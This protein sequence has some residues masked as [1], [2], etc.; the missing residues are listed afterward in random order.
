MERNA[1][2]IGGGIASLAA[3]VYLIRDANFPG[4]NIHIIEAIPLLGGSN[5]GAGDPLQGYVN[6]GGRMLNEETYEN[7]WDLLKSIPSLECPGMNLYEEIIDFDHRHPTHSNARLIDKYG[8]VCDVKKMGLNNTDRLALIKLALSSE[9]SLEGM[10]IAKWFTRSPHFFQ[11][12]FWY[13]WQTTFAFQKWSS[14]VELQ[15]YMFRFLHLFPRIETLEDV[16]RTPYNQYESLILPIQKYLQDNGVGLSINAR[17]IDIDFEGQNPFRAQ[18][19]HIKSAEVE[20]TIKLGESDICILTLGSMTDNSRLGTRNTP[21]VFAT[22]NPISGELWKNIASKVPTLGNPSAFYSNPNE[23]VWE[24]FTI[25]SKS[26]AL[27]N[28]ITKKFNNPPGNALMTFKDSSWLLSIVIPVQPHYKNQ[29]GTTATV[30]WGYALNM[31]T[32]GDFI[33][34][35]IRDCT[36]DEMLTELIGHL[37]LVEH[38]EIIRNDV[39]NIIPAMLPYIISMFQPRKKGDRPLVVPRHSQNFALIG[40]YVEIPQDVVFTEEY[41]VRG[42]REAVYS[43][44]H[45]N[46]KVARVTPHWKKIS[47]LLAALKKSFQ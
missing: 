9:K 26:S 4:K 7:L 44:L 41:S 47:I 17:V 5:D 16:T 2:L 34:K 20:N 21:A 11:T 15:R 32:L 23:T 40:Q 33:K 28:L 22:Q 35:P 43:L 10:T 31:D 27:I 19:I 25:T 8:V 12:N 36:G 24:S 42:A 45:L 3:A 14:L 18:K 30:M 37:G 6:R 46:K 1:Y 39:V 13:L 29:I 38:G